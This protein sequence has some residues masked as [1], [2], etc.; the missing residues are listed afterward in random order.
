LKTTLC[1][2]DI[3]RMNPER[4]CVASVDPQG[5]SIRPLLP[6]TNFRLSW[7]YQNGKIIKPF[8]CLKLDLLEQRPKPPHTEDWFVDPDSIEILYDLDTQRRYNFLKRIID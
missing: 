4:I 5:R 3:T 7:C 6:D 2:T 1:I 8:T